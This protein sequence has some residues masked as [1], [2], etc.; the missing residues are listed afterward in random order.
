[1]AP[2]FVPDILISPRW[3]V[4]PIS[5]AIAKVAPMKHSSS[6]ASIAKLVG[7][8]RQHATQNIIAAPSLKPP[9]YGFVVW[10]ALRQHVPLRCTFCTSGTASS[11]STTSPRAD[12][13]H[14]SFKIQLARRGS[15]RALGA[16]LRQGWSGELHTRG[17]RVAGEGGPPVQFHAPPSDL[18]RGAPGSHLGASHGG[19]RSL[20]SES[21][22]DTSCHLGHCTAAKSSRNRNFVDCAWLHAYEFQTRSRCRSVSWIANRVILGSSCGT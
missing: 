15:V 2:A 10:V 11:R 9:M 3:V 13:A 20:Q 17:R 14:N 22:N 19:K 18:P 8:L 1:M 6:S 4:A 21:P 16:G 7:D 5:M 12:H